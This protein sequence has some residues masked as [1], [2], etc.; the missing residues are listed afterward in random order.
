[1]ED[2]LTSDS[3]VLTENTE[4]PAAPPIGFRR[5]VRGATWSWSQLVLTSVIGFFL[6]PYVVHHLGSTTYGVWV[7]VGS[8]VSYMALLDLG[9]RGAVVRFVS[10]DQPRGR[11]DE[12]SRAVSAALWFRI[13]LGGI[14]LLGAMMLSF[15]APRI[16]HI[17]PE[18]HTA[19]RAAILI[20]GTSVALSLCYGV[21][22]GV[23]NALLRFDLLAISATGLSALNA[24]GFVLLLGRG[25]GI[26][27]M[28]LWQ[29]FVGLLNGAFLLASAFRVY[30]QLK[31]FF[32]PPG[33]DLVRKFGG[34]SVFLF[35]NAAAGQVIYYTDSVVI[36]ATLPVGAITVYALGFAPTQYLRQ[37]VS[38]LAV[39]FLPAAS[40]ISARGDHEQLRR[41]LI[42]GTRAVM[43][44]ALTVEAGLMFRG[45][46]FISLWMGPQ[47]R[48]GSGRV[49][50]VLTL[51][52]IFMAGNFCAGNVVYG[53]SKHK[54]V[55]I[56]SIFEAV[57]NLVLSLF[58]V[59]RWGVIGVAWGTVLPSWI[60]NAILWPRFI[61][62]LLDI[63]L[64]SYILQSWIRPA[65]ATLPFAAGCFLADRFWP[66]THLTGFFLQMAALL[67]L[68][69]AGFSLTFGREVAQV[70]RAR[71]WFGGAQTSR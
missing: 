57:A 6:S 34:Y 8:I 37:I 39:T 40:T 3:R 4:P 66:A 1:M 65:L 38:S 20:S 56:W 33:R 15:L 58:L 47:Y 36:G 42:Q 49:L 69:L 29:L 12:A 5:I 59:R 71:R 46:T 45:G 21:F 62:K 24:A 2:V 26:V 7:L 32:R 53:L 44:I 28:A 64:G 14:V 11:H 9:I 43:A 25:H 61:T 67:P 19:T 68:A 23:L 16:F 54:R 30:P 50:Q 70:L 41:L 17:P 60:I 35:V 48:E 63:P 22:S 27:A 10:A 18:L 51:A 55:A 52:W 31:L 13:W